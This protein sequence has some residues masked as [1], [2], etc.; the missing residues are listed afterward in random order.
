MVVDAFGLGDVSFRRDD[1]DAISGPDDF[2]GKMIEIG[3]RFGVHHI[4][5]AT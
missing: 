1:K 5:E 3:E 4:V 2:N